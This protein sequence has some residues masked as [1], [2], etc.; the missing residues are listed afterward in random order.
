MVG[1]RFSTHKRNALSDMNESLLLVDADLDDEDLH[2]LTTELCATIAEETSLEPSLVR[3]VAVPGS[4]GEPVTVGA[5]VL[6]LITSGAIAN[7]ISVLAA[8][9]SRQSS[10]TFNIRR[11]D[12]QSLEISAQNLAAAQVQDTIR[13]AQ[14]FLIVPPPAP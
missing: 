3:G 11:P 8:R 1:S 5:I 4:K 7:L 10:I 14:Q 9:V 2:R 13:T 12:G 6:A